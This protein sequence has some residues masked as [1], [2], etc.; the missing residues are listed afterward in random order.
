MPVNSRAVDIVH[1]DSR[2]Y[3]CKR[4]EER[5]GGGEEAWKGRVNVKRKRIACFELNIICRDL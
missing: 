5:E 3:V 4:G 1:V 2:V